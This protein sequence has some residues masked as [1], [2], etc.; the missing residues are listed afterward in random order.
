MS[1][2]FITGTDTNCGKTYVT[3]IL[4]DYLPNAKALKPIASGCTRVGDELIN[5]DAFLLQ[6]KSSLTMDEVNPWRFAPPIAPHLAAEQAGVR[7]TAAELVKHCFSV[8]LTPDETL[9]IEG[10]GG[11]LVPINQHE[12]WV[13]FLLAS[14]IPVIFVVGIKLGCI[15]HALLSAAVLQ[16]NNI[17]C[18][19]W[20][21]NC[22]DPDME[23]LAENIS[24]L[25]ERL[26]FR[27]LATIPYN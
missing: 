7:V 21:A 1:R 2:Y 11:L 16:Q 18:T 22:I 4:M 8:P 12:T 10:A 23:A 9:L 19:G 5:D 3:S 15:N 20:I 27:K 17:Q 14:N 13:D 25:E 26:P 6:S 24:T